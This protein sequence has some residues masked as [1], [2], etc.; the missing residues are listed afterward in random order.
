MRPIRPSRW[1]KLTP[2][3]VVR[4][5]YE[6]FIAYARAY[7]DALPTYTNLDN[8]LVGTVA[9]SSITLVNIC[10]SITY[11]SAAA[12]GPLVSAPPPPSDVAPLT[13]PDN[14]QRYL[15]SEDPTCAEWD[16]LLKQFADDTR[17]WQALDPGVRAS[18]WNAEQ[19]SIVDAVIPQMET[20]AD[21]VEAL[22]AKSSNPTLRDFATLAAQYRRAYAAA[23]PSY[24]AGD[25]YLSN[26][27]ARADSTIYE[28]C[29]A[30]G[31]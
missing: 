5:L 6:Q 24:T 28:A 21:E 16:R 8:H 29:K 12:R 3:R 19:R 27:S 11:G 30:V 9:A 15:T 18:D 20:F 10:S 2:H 1:S 13:D 25:S 31:G 4:E 22:G 23:L 14:P 26:V 7:V 17:P